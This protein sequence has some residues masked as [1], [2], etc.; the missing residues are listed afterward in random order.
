MPDSALRVFWYRA[1]EDAVIGMVWI[2]QDVVC[3][4]NHDLSF[5]VAQPGIEPGT[6]SLLSSP[7][8]DFSMDALISVVNDPSNLAALCPD[9]HKELDL[10]FITLVPS[11]GIG[12]S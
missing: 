6:L 8:A 9:H 7:V 2:R 11:L 5:M 1:V 10:G 4:E 3:S 12:P